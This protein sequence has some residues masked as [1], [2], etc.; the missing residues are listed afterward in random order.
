MLSKCEALQGRRA[1]PE[2]LK[3]LFSCSPAACWMRNSRAVKG[4]LVMDTQPGLSHQQVLG[5][6]TGASGMVCMCLARNQSSSCVL[7]YASQRAEWDRRVLSLLQAGS[8]QLL[9]ARAHL[10]Q[11]SMW[12]Q[13]GWFKKNMK[14]CHRAAQMINSQ[15]RPSLHTESYKGT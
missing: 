7:A 9:Y 12:S 1:T 15:V 2:E 4:L 3:M 10:P 11:Q 13:A 8:D 5:R 14:M 6:H